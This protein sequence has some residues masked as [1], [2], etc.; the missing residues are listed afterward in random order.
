MVAISMPVTILAGLFFMHTLGLTLNIL[1]LLS[2]GMSV[3]ILV[4]NSIVVLDAIVSKLGETGDPK[5]SARLGAGEVALAVVASAGTNMVVL[6]PIALIYFEKHRWADILLILAIAA[7]LVHS[8]IL[9]GRIDSS[10]VSESDKGEILVKLEFP[11]GYDLAQ[12]DMRVKEAEDLIRAC[13]S[14][15]IPS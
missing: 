5:E 8:L 1:T 9:A 13:P 7:A 15:G 11:T 12:T 2:V 6:Y 10:M 4:T 14:C 3:G